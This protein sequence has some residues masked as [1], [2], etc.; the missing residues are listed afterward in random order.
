MKEKDRQLD[1]M[2]PSYFET[3]ICPDCWEGR[4]YEKLE[5]LAGEQEEILEQA[6]ELG[7]ELPWGDN[8]E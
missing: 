7:I 6:R 3:R 8:D 1:P 2:E 4:A 5:E